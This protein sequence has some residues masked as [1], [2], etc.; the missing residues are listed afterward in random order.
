MMIQNC[1]SKNGTV[2]LLR[3]KSF[4]HNQHDIEILQTVNYLFIKLG[5]CKVYFLPHN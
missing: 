2:R 5:L 1:T 3:L 4:A